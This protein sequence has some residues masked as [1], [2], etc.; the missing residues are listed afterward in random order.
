MNTPLS[1]DS[2][3]ELSQWIKLKLIPLPC[4]STFD[5][6]TAPSPSECWRAMTKNPQPPPPQK[7]EWGPAGAPPMPSRCSARKQV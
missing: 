3:K 7:T 1:P 6:P 2:Q 5:T 4:P